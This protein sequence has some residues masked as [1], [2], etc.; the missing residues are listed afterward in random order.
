MS[1]VQS[2]VTQM[3]QW[4]D[5]YA[6]QLEFWNRLKTLLQQANSFVI[7][8]AG[9]VVL[10]EQATEPTQAEWEDAWEL[11]TGLDLPIPPSAQLH[12]W[13]TNEDDFGGLY[14]TV[15]GNVTVYRRDNLYP[16]GASILMETAYK[17]DLLSSVQ[18]AIG[19][20]LADH[21][22]VTI[23]VPVPVNLTLEYLLYA[24][25]SAGS[26]FWGADFLVDGIKVG[27]QYLGVATN[28]GI[29]NESASNLVHAEHTIY[30]VAPGEYLIQALFGVCGSPASPPTVQ[31]GGISGAT[32]FGARVLTVR[33]I[34]L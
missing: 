11:Q 25:L 33:G 1:L 8:N 28:W 27:T 13:N 16:R 20:N 10:L 32:A 12:W 30:N 21:P 7:D 4:P 31:I 26:G 14:G 18:Y 19:T 23:E 2:F 3:G 6:R 15:E 29:C 5:D 34:A 24:N 22:N 17:T 9:L